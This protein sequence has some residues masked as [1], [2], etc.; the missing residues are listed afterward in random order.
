MRERVILSG[1]VRGGGREA[2]C[3][4]EAVRVSLPGALGPNRPI[5]PL[6]EHGGMDRVWVPAPNALPGD[7]VG[8][9]PTSRLLSGT[10]CGF[11]NRLVHDATTSSRIYAAVIAP[12][13]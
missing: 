8:L 11:C 6:G 2:T 1:V 13:I 7:S 3:T 10:G 12:A 4:I 5:E 9:G